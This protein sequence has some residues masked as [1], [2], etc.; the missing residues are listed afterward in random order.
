MPQYTNST[1]TASGIVLNATLD[2]GSNTI[3]YTATATNGASATNTQ[4]ADLSPSQTTN[5]SALTGPLNASGATLGSPSAFKNALTSITEEVLVQATQAAATAAATDT[6][7][8]AAPTPPTPVPA[9]DNPNPTPAVSSPLIENSSPTTPPTTDYSG[10]PDT[11]LLITPNNAG[12]VTAIG[13]PV[14]QQTIDDGTDPYVSNGVSTIPP[15]TSTNPSSN[16]AIGINLL[17]AQSTAVV[18]DAQSFNQGK[19][20]RVRIG[21]APG[22]NY[23]YAVGDRSKA[24][25]LAPLIDTKGV[26]FPY[27]PNIT[28]S[29]AAG[30]DASELVHS[31]YKVYQYKG[32]SVDNITITGDFTAQDTNE[33]N[34]LLAVIHFF[35]SVTKMFYG[36]DENPKNGIPPP[37][38]YLSGFGAYQFDNHP[39]AITNFTYNTP[40]DVDY[41]RAGSQTNN[42]GQNTGQQVTQVNSTIQL[43]RLSKSGLIIQ[44]PNFSTPNVLIN[45]DPTYVPT[46]VSISITAYPIVSRNDISNNFSLAKYATGGLLRGSVNKSGGI[47]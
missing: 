38:C 1:T 23:L 45:S 31:N 15:I 40:T 34:Y 4:S 16:N 43:N 11:D 46:K 36:Q 12:T 17:S 13:T 6:P 9:A 3:T 32:S 2:T 26:I 41:I 44:P 33:A 47:W 24:G 39:M 27:T 5:I 35:R 8:P 28:V 18:Q 10:N 19:D 20:W 21:L 30:Y 37:L 14:P 42:A 7:V 25:I 29:Y 22:A